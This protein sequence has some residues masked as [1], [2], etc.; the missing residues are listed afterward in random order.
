M[1]TAVQAQ[2][3]DSHLGTEMATA[4]YSRVWTEEPRWPRSSRVA[5]VLAAA[6]ACWAVPL[7]VAY[8]LAS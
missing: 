1:E 8:L 6:L 3:L 5:F 7:L 2:K 4:S